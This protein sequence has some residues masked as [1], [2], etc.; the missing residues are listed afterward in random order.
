MFR[1]WLGQ[2]H[3]G[4][5]LSGGSGWAGLP[6][7]ATGAVPVLLCRRASVGGP[8]DAIRPVAA[9]GWAPLSAR[10][11]LRGCLGSSGGTKA[12]LPLPVT[13]AQWSRVLRSWWKV[14]R[15]SSS[16]SR[17]C[18]V[19][20][21]GSRWS[22]SIRL[23]WQPWTEQQGVG[24]HQRDLLRGGRPAAQVGDVGH[25][26]PVGDDQFDDGLAEQVSATDTGTGPT[27]AISHSSSPRTRPRRS[28][29]ASMRSNAR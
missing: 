18:L 1:W 21:Q 22:Y 5:G 28:A 19:C 7:G 23:R 3:L 24:P 27:P 11:W 10:F 16:S 13:S 15:G 26:H 8:S 14:H 2:G 29:A 25:V 9:D 4:G 6:G 17:V 12:R 20:A